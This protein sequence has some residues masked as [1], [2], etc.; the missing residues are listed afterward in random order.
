[1][2]VLTEVLPSA[3]ILRRV[4]YRR[5][6]IV[7]GLLALVVVASVI[8][9][10]IGAVQID[11]SRI[12]RALTGTGTIADHRI[13]IGF[14]LPR[15]LVGLCVGAGLAVSGVILQAVTRNPLASPAVIGV[16][17][18]AG[19]AALLVLS[20]SSSAA[21]IWQVPAAAFAGA[22]VAGGTTYLLSRRDGIVNP[23]RL[24][25]IGVAF[26]GL[27]L[28]LIQLII[29]TTSFTGDVQAALRWLTGSLWGRTWIHVE[30]VAPWTL[31]LIPLAWFLADQLNLLGLG[32]DVPRAL[33][34]RL[35]AL[36]LGLLAIA[37]A[38]AGSA[39]A[40]GGTIAFVGLLAPHLCRRLVG[41]GHRL[42]IPA[43]ACIGALLVVVADALGR[44]IL[45]P[46]EIPVGLFTAVL[47]APYFLLQLRKG[48]HA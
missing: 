14:R 32:D 2:T 38:L 9:I 5:R 8:S 39:V 30:Q 28:A 43:S 27:S 36:K 29:V 1:M 26:G 34:S 6:L 44:A 37:V 20:F 10:G 7:V 24:A 11:L 40:V 18:G 46:A 31:V 41:P 15:I 48:L 25:L 45:P 42:L 4:G 12:L 17:G 19:L 13:V 3:T 33:G 47:G 23:G 16:N 21:A 35:E 22:A